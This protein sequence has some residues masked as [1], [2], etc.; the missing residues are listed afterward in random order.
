MGLK[1]YFVEIPANADL[2]GVMIVLYPPLPTNLSKKG[3]SFPFV[4]EESIS[5]FFQATQYLTASIDG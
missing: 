5:C 3:T 4:N 1:K 2:E